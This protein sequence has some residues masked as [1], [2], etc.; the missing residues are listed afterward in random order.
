MVSSELSL[1]CAI[2][3]PDWDPPVDVVWYSTIWEYE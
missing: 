2:V 3:K 1:L